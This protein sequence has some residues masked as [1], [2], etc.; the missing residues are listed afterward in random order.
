[1][2]E[3]VILTA[4]GKGYPPASLE[5]MV[6][7]AKGRVDKVG[8]TE[9][10]EFRAEELLKISRFLGIKIEFFIDPDADDIEAYRIKPEEDMLLDFAR[11]MEGGPGQAL[12]LLMD[13]LASKGKAVKGSGESLAEEDT[14]I[15]R[16][17]AERSMKKLNRG[18]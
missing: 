10:K 5:R 7:L 6:G 8:R 17:V 3:K 12:S 1:M 9:G 2:L 4:K 14:R 18:A 15:A 13:F 11:K 16:E